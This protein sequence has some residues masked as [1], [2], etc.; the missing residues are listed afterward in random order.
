MAVG[1]FTIESLEQQTGVSA[2]TLR[3]WIRLKVIPKPI[4]KGRGARYED[5]H[6]IRARAAKVLRSQ[7]V[8]LAGIRARLGALPDE[9]VLKLVPPAPRAV[10]AEGIPVPP[11]APTYPARTYELVT[12][13]DGLFLMVDPSRGAVLRRIADEIYRYYGSVSPR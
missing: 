1:T 6:V 5:R 13:M 2:R 10:T 7:R 12:L 3:H 11:P 9:E 4:G 8:S